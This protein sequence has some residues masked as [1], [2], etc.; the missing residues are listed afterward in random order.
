M[1]I[2]VI[3]KG[4]RAS[5]EDFLQMVER[6]CQSCPHLVSVGSCCLVGVITKDMLYVG[7]LGDSRAV[8][9]RNRIPGVNE[10]V[11]ER[12]TSDHNVKDE[13]VR[14]EVI[15]HHPDDS[16]ILVHTRG[17]WRIKGIIQVMPRP[18]LASEIL[19]FHATVAGKDCQNSDRM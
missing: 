7:N 11:A 13:E 5:E 9:G 16:R 1:S 8:L 14:K 2:E 6:S 12:L 4:F 15:K 19:I 3:K 10:V 18:F 17:A